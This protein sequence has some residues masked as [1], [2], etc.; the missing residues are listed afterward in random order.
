MKNKG[1]MFGLDARIALAIFGAL[2]V[3][4]GAALYSAIQESSTVK[5]TTIFSEV[6]KATEAYMLDTGIDLPGSGRYAFAHELIESTENGWKGPYL[7]GEKPSPGNHVILPEINSGAFFWILKQRD[8]TYGDLESTIL[9]D[10]IAS[11]PC[12]YW[13]KAYTDYIGFGDSMDIIN[14]LD[15]KIDNSDGLD[16]GN[17][18]YT[19]YMDGTTKKPILYYKLSRLIKQP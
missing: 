15:K 18:R 17:I 14:Q 9:Q 10:C 12:Y 2:S 19:Y 13:I 11:S 4:S 6:S 16:K 1:A 5:I 7:Q 8:D 3:I